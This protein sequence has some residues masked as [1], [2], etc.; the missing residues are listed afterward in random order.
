MS[1]RI[2]IINWTGGRK[3]WGCQATSYGML[4]DL[5]EAA[6]DT[7]VGFHTVP[8]EK[9]DRADRFVRRHF[10]AFLRE[11]LQDAKPSPL[12][13]MLF[14]S[15]VRLAY[16][17]HVAAIRASDLI[18]FMA[19][20]T[21]TGDSFQ[22]G[23][24]L[25]MLPYYAAT[26]AGRPVISLNQ[27]IFSRSEW[28][29]PVLRHAYGK[30]A[31]NAVRE[32]ESLAYAQAIGLQHVHLIPDS[33]F[34]AR[35]LEED[36]SSFLSPLPA[37]PLLCITGSG[38]LSS[39][40]DAAY[41]RTVLEVAREQGLQPC[42]TLWSEE[43]RGA[44]LARASEVGCLPVV[45]PKAGVDYRAL[46]TIL[47][48]ARALVGGRYH[49]SIQAAAVGT[50]FLALDSGTHKTRGLLSMLDYPVPEHSFDDVAGIRQDLLR[51]LGERDA[52]S[53]HLQRQMVRVDEQRQAGIRQ[54]GELLHRV[55]KG[56]DNATPG[57][58][59]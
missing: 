55:A 58:L 20:G 24:R 25:L 45:F 2:A 14:R 52:L 15:L 26:E 17:R 44:L 50:P 1:L 28:F 11:H 46:S 31:F 41:L 53:A 5:R 32:P 33:A 19:E 7:A 21:M 16:R 30:F 39:S 37:A 36:A 8:F 49:S 35:P 59:N 56:S 29:V 13:R 57:P 34:R 10:S 12:R 3:N 51:V 43:A 22:G 38:S 47:Q 54:L 23:I 27:T 40:L 48:S 42:A 18:V 9:N 6:G 4:E